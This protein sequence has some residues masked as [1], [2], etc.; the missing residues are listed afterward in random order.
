M[1]N[2]RAT[3]YATLKIMLL[4]I[5]FF[6]F[7]GCRPRASSTEQTSS[8]AKTEPCSLITKEEVAAASGDNV[9]VTPHPD[10]NACAYD[11]VPTSA[12][13]GT[14]RGTIVVVVFTPD[15]PQ[16]A[17]FGLSSDDRTE[18]KPISGLGDKAVLF[19]SKKSPDQGAKAIQVL[20]GKHYIAVG[21]STADPPVSVD[22]LTSLAARA[23]SRLP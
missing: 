6:A 3:V 23:L 9:A 21:V 12:P 19:T 7:C 22:T 15:S 13:K 10:H 16:F 17:K 18:A 5:A 14:L 1:N 20:K 8:T 4:I 2:K 11:L